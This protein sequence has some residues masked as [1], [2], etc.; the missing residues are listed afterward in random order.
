MKQGGFTLIEIAVVLVIIGLIL[1]GI[2]NSRSLISGMQAKDVVA[3]V[4]DLRTASAYFKQRYNYLPGD[5]PVN[6][7]DIAN[8]APPGG[9]GD[10]SIGGTINAQGQAA[11]GSEVAEAPWQLYSAGLLGKINSSEPRRRIST[12]FGGV[13]LASN[14]TASGLIAGYGNPSVRNVII[15]VSLPCDIVNEVDNK[16]DDGVATTGRAIGNACGANGAV[17]F[18][19]VAL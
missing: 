19:A 18:Y 12:T 9:N 15:F 17:D 6:A 1:G 7:G 16:V 2:L 3:I 4:D 5:F 13:H 8:V 10:G 14:A 11:A